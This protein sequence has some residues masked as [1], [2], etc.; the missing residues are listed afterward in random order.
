MLRTLSGR[1]HVV[2]TGVALV[3]PGF[4]GSRVVATRVRIRRL[5]PLEIRGY[6]ES[7]EP[8]DKAGAYA[9]Q[10]LGA[11]LVERVD[12]DWTNVVGLPLGVTR[13]LL[14]RAAAGPGGRSRSLT[15]KTMP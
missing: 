12:G 3:G 15:R 11:V 10:G 8:M 14:A 9:A 5:T 1:V 2:Y 13:A 6:V 4:E 7:G